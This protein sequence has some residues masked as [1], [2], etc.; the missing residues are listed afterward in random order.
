VKEFRMWI[1]FQDQILHVARTAIKLDIKSM[2]VYLLKIMWGKE[3]LKKKINLKLA[4][5]GNMDILR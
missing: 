4:K 3:L 2:N 5:I 1:E